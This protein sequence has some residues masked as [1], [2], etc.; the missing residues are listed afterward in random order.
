MSSDSWVREIEK[1]NPLDARQIHKEIRLQDEIEDTREGARRRLH[2]GMLD[3][4]NAPLYPDVDMGIPYN[5]KTFS[6]F[7]ARPK[8]PLVAKARSTVQDWAFAESDCPI[9]TLAGVPGTG[10]THLAQAA[11]ASVKGLCLYRTESSLLSEAMSRMRTHTVETLLEAVCAVPWLVID[12]MGV[13]AT[14][15]WGQGVLDRIVD[16]RYV[17]AQARDGWTLITTNLSGSD[18]LPRIVRRL[19]E[20]GVSTVLDLKDTRSYYGK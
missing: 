10:K 17:K 5:G 4:I 16:A 9:I 14:S 6:G 18:M 8:Y 15:E 19:T 20:P 12:D 2:E 11:A 13:S 7:I 3:E 1:V